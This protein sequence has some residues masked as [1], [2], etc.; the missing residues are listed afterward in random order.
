MK[1]RFLLPT[2]Y[3]LMPILPENVPRCFGS[4][5]SLAPCRVLHAP[6]FV[7][8]PFP[9]ARAWSL[10]FRCSA[11]AFPTPVVTGALT[12]AGQI[13]FHVTGFKQTR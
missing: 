2:A 4:L 10:F 8:V 7:P 9:R 5:A 12:N 11:A 3:C 1:S 13:P 6:A